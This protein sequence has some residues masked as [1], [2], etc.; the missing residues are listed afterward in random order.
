LDNAVFNAFTVFTVFC[1]N[2]VNVGGSWY[3]VH[4]GGGTAKTTR[5]YAH[6]VQL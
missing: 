6:V 3:G 2:T 4:G 5:C 1:S